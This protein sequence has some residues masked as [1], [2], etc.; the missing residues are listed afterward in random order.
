MLIKI[1]WLHVSL[2]LPD[3]DCIGGRLQLVFSFFFFSPPALKKRH[4]GNREGR[5]GEKSKRRL[6]HIQDGCVSACLIVWMCGCMIM[7]MYM[8][9][10]NLCFVSFSFSHVM[11]LRKIS[12]FLR[13]CLL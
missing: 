3:G 6:W 12:I 11:T 4:L 8:Y 7:Y 2:E 1:I 13:M 10:Y 5:R 9:M